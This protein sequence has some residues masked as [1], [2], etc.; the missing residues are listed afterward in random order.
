MLLHYIRT[1]ACQRQCYNITISDEASDRRP[2]MT[3][4]DQAR[5]TPAIARPSPRRCMKC[6]GNGH[7]CARQRRSDSRP[8]AGACAHTA[9][10]RFLR[11]HVRRPRQNAFRPERFR[12]RFDGSLDPA[13]CA[14]ITAGIE[15]RAADANETQMPQRLEWHQPQR[16][17]QFAQCAVAVARIGRQPAATHPTPGRPRVHRQRAFEQTVGLGEAARQRQ[18]PAAQAQG[19][20]V[21][22]RK[23]RRFVGVTAA[24]A[25]GPFTA[26]R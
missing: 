23:T 5:G 7:A 4:A 1:S 22:R 19:E 3:D 26:C 17:L 24:T 20:R 6:G 13:R 12:T 11:R 15:M 9:V 16:V 10:L 2:P 14:L 18:R 8:C 25:H 21:V